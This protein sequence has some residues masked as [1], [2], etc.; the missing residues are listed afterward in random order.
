M[1]K[2]LIISFLTLFSISAIA[3][4]N[5]R[6]EFYETCTKALNQC[7]KNKELNEI[8]NI[9]FHE[10]FFLNKITY[11]ENLIEDATFGDKEI[12]FENANPGDKF[13]V[14]HI[15]N[16]PFHTYKRLLIDTEKNMLIADYNFEIST[17]LF[18]CT[19]LN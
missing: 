8:V 15:I 13:K 10:G 5:L 19:K 4:T 9:S 7:S 14:K 17:T 6:C 2:L 12:I 1:K 3:E 18:L 11:N 16:K